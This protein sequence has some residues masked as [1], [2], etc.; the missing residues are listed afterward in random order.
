[1]FHQRL[2]SRIYYADSRHSQ[3]EINPRQF[4]LD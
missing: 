2:Q 4:N 3:F 1:M